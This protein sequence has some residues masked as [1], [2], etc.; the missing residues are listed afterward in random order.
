[1]IR[2]AAHK[3]ASLA[4]LFLLIV[5]GKAPA[6]ENTLTFNH[7]F[8]IKA[9]LEKQFGI[10]TLECFPFIENIGFTE[11]QKSL[12]Q[13]C[14]QGAETLKQTLEA[15]PIPN[16]HTVGI[17]DRFMWVGGFHSLLI[18]WKST[19]EDVSRFLNQQ[20]PEPEQKRFLE[21]IR[22]LKQK[23][24]NKIDV[25]DLY[26]TQKI[27]NTQCLAG[28][29][30]LFSVVKNL[31]S[32]NKHWPQIVITD[33]FA[34]F[35]DPDALGLKFDAPAEDLMNFLV[36]KDTGNEWKL[37]KKMYAVIEEKYGEALRRRLHLANLTCAVNLSPEECLQG[38]DGLYKA[39]LA[40]QGRPWG[41]ITIDKY[42][43]LILNDYDATIRY[44]LNYSDIIRYFSVKA[45]TRQTQENNTL[46]EDMEKRSKGNSTQLRVVCDLEELHS[47]LC[48]R[49][50]KTF[51]AFLKKHPDYRADLP[52][53]NL[54]LVDG[55][56][57]SRINF[58]LNSKTRASYIYV[59]AHSDLAEFEDRLL[60]FGKPPP[61][62]TSP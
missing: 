61:R 27:S 58:A 26:C 48:V 13:K 38:A 59:D 57:L 7:L 18:P 4:L 29:Q 14:L 9:G 55:C 47:A 3:T 17:S 53:E 21:T 2:F 34:P 39:S 24:K 42:N 19:Q 41:T 31:I 12:I 16:L 46:A 15:N 35:K 52:W 36:F 30:N 20:P 44:D 32:K 28:Y 45:T 50:F 54:M 10:R 40:L 51:F 8:D 60:A 1:M 62:T 25:G 5:A 6:G 43:T 33:S 11:D 37:R 49:G 22:D 23:I 56:R